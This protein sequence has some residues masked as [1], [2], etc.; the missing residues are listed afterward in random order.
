MSEDVRGETP[1]PDRF[2]RERIPGQWNR[3]LAGQQKAAE[4]ER[5]LLEEMEAVDATIR[6]TVEGEDGGTFFLNVERGRMEPGE[7]PAHPPFLT[8]VQDRAAFEALAREA[9]DSALGFLGGLTGLADDLKLT[10][11][12]LANLAKLSGTLRFEVRGEN[13]FAL[14]TRFGDGPVAEQ[15]DCTLAVEADT[16]AELRAGRLDPQQAF[17]SQKIEASGDLQLAMQLALAVLSPD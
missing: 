11:T 12:R 16:Y 6:V 7:S 2:Y 5:K 4:R 15:A 3:A 8:L 10:R 17:M 9:G 1:S 14:V 13:G